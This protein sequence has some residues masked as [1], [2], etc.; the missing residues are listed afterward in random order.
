MPDKSKTT[1]RLIQRRIFKTWENASIYRDLGL[2]VTEPA[3]LL[4]MNTLKFLR[5]RGRK[6]EI[7]QTEAAQFTRA[8]MKRPQQGCYR[9]GENLVH[10]KRMHKYDMLELTESYCFL[11][12]ALWL[13]RREKWLQH[14]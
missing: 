10:C 5:K 12:F 4:I 7:S 1:A 8:R 13:F 2:S 14:P 3:R 9:F 6:D 11:S